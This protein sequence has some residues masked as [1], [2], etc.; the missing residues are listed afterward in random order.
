MRIITEPTWSQDASNKW[1]LEILD[2]DMSGAFT[3]KAKFYVSNDRSR[4]DEV[5]KEV[6]IEPDKKTFVFDQSW[7]NVFFYGKRGL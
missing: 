2:L 5:C 4:N 3:G 6:E 1:H 7:N